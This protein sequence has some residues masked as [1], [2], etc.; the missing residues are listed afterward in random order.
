[1][2]TSPTLQRFLYLVLLPFLLPFP[3]HA[4]EMPGTNDDGFV[5]TITSTLASIN[6][7]L[8]HK[9]EAKP[10][11]CYWVGS[12]YG[13][14][15]TADLCG[16][17]VWA[18][19]QTPDSLACD[20]IPGN[21]T[22]KI[23]LIRRGACGFSQKVYHA[24][25]A[26][27][28]AVI[29]LNHLSNANDGPCINYGIDRTP[30]NG[31]NG[32]GADSSI[33]IPSI[34]L[35]RAT[36]T[37][38]ADAIR[39]NRQVYACFSLPRMSKATAARQ[40][41]TPVRHVDTMRHITVHFTNRNTTPLTN[42]TLKADIKSPNGTVR[43]ITFPI[44]RLEPGVDTFVVFPGYWPTQMKGKFEVVFSNNIYKEPRDTLRRYF[45]HTEYT[46]ALD[47]GVVDSFGVGPA[48]SVS[49]DDCYILQGCRY[50]SGAIKGITP[51]DAT[52]VTFGLAN[53]DSVFVPGDPEA[54]EILFILYD[55][56]KKEDGVG[57]FTSSF[58]DLADNIIGTG[59][60][61]MNGKEPHDKMIITRLINV[62]TGEIGIPLKPNHPYYIISLYDGFLAGTGR[63]LRFSKSKQQYYLDEY[64]LP[65]T[66]VYTKIGGGT[67][68][69]GW[70]GS[71]I[72]HRIETG[73]PIIG[74]QN[75]PQLDASKVKI[76]PNPAVDFAD[77]RF[78]LDGLNNV[79][80]SIADN[81]GRVVRSV[82]QKDIQNGVVQVDTKTLTAGTYLM[83]I[84][85]G[86][87]YR[88]EK[89]VVV[90]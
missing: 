41:A 37:Q 56:D 33:R 85:T 4:Q 84:R 25:Q 70:E 77:V 63:C 7:T 3:N 90:K 16:E 58:V 52:Y 81:R 15:L 57:D 12:T 88:V 35:Q 18:Y 79:A 50:W 17:V 83:W 67:L 6:Q 82:V 11:D 23:A 51:S 53:A 87:G 45:E 43:S 55:A 29:I 9:R 14:S 28:I 1:M 5:V 48:N 72:I 68:F 69:S 46:F 20:P 62:N 2:K 44:D 40:Y 24:Q 76:T 26:G 89:L 71:T 31:M 21:L 59:I 54:N 34:F 32:G 13:P 47:N 22:G 38:L 10:G 78:Q 65:N 27:A 64:G 60:Y 30:F 8:A 80:I 66:P 36:G 75:P 73:I 86:E 19:D 42:I 49:P 61:I 74:T 39:A